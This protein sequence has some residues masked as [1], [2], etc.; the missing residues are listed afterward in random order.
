MR[1]RST[2]HNIIRP[3]A[4]GHPKMKPR[5]CVA[6]GK[7]HVRAFLAEALEELGFAACKC[8][9]PEDIAELV[10]RFLPELIVLGVSDGSTVGIGMLST[11]ASRQCSGR[12]LLVGSRHSSPVAA[13]QDFGQ[14]LGL[15]MLPVLP[16]PFEEA[17]L[18]ARVAPLMPE[19]EPPSAAVDV[20]DALG[21]GW[22]ALWY[23]AKVDMRTLGIGGAEA[24]LRLCHPSW[25]VIEP[26]C[27]V[28]DDSDPNFRA[29]SSFV[30]AR[31]LEDWRSFVPKHGPLEL[32]IRLPIDALRDPQSVENLCHRIPG[33]AAFPGLIVEIDGAEL[34]R[35]LPRMRDVAGQ[36]R[37]HKIG[38][39]IGDF[40]V[41]WPSGADLSYF[42]FV[43]IKVDRRFV[44]GCAGDRPKRAICQRILKLA[45]SVGARTVAEG[46]E[47][48]ADFLCVR[49]LGFDM[50]Q[51][52]LFAHPMPA[53]RFA[54]TV[55]GRSTVM[56]PRRTAGPEDRIAG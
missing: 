13:F 38:L 7:P 45:D 23:E 20:P 4:F 40:G 36:V 5:A 14:E 30:I 11:L 28:A 25:G 19:H 32:A 35:D 50:A 10:E 33:D 15:A 43:E 9:Q 39:S 1:H 8:E 3:V 12:I 6:G 21:A 16:T 34:L 52:L 46:V 48:R 17:S 47:T 49:D 22:L 54:R 56:K 18:R 29:L 24:L 37:F 2:G 27:L 26:T 51:G 31:V 44:S 41:Q 55:L 42:P 53:D